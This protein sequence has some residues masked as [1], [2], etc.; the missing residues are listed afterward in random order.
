MWVPSGL[1]TVQCRPRD[2]FRVPWGPVRWTTRTP[3][4]WG[5]LD[6]TAGEGWTPTAG[7]G[8]DPTR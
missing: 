4:G 3:H 6:P 7:G 2:A 5:G 1:F 8:L